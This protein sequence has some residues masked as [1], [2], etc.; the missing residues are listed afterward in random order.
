MNLR[1]AVVLLTGASGG[2]GRAT[3]RALV[4]RGARVLLTA[5]NRHSLDVLR[6]KLGND[7]DV[8]VFAADLTSSA[9]RERLVD[10]AKHWKGGI[11]V[12]INNAGIGE[13]RSFPQQTS[14]RIVELIATNLEA[15]LQ[16]TRLLLPHL[17]QRPA[18][19]VLNVGS[20]YGAIAYP[21][22]AIYSAAKYGL[23]GFSEAL[24][25]ELAD[26][27]VRVQYLAPRATRTEMNSPAVDALN[28]R[29]GS[30]VDPPEKVAE[31][32]CR[33]L[34]SSAPSRTI[35]WPERLYVRLNAIAPQII[36]GALRK[37]LPT[38]QPYAEEAVPYVSPSA[39]SRTTAR[40]SS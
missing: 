20:V 11:D 3:A 34:E 1:S 40:T 24:R 5:R 17:L 35:G 28:E 15:P 9:D 36:D 2:I 23:R 10:Y 8:G 38:I 27:S 16:L 19:H 18:A 33:M 4:E 25:R 37:Q 21:G 14:D 22:Y 32:I 13:F 7:E 31:A 6:A 26:T 30:V 12:L 39:D 29:L